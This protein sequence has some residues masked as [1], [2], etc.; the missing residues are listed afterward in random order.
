M[1]KTA[2]S[3]LLHELE[4]SVESSSNLEGDIKTI[5]KTIRVFVVF[6]FS[7]FKFNHFSHF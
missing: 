5:S 2:K 4:T 3:Q 6:C 7:F 1:R